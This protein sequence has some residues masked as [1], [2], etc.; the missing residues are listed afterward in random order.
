VISGPSD[1][2]DNTG[3]TSGYNN[4][5]H[6]LFFD[7]TS[8]EVSTTYSLF[9]PVYDLS[10]I[11]NPQCSFATYMQG[12]CVG[13]L[14]IDIEEPAG[15]GN[16]TNIF[17]ES[18]DIGEFWLPQIIQLCDVTETLIAFRFSVVHCDGSIGV[19]V[20]GDIA[21]DEFCV[22]KGPDCSVCSVSNPGLIPGICNDNGTPSNPNDD[23]AII[24][25]NPTGHLI[26]TNYT[27]S[28][29]VSGS[30]VYGS[31][32]NITIPVGLGDLNLS[33]TDDNDPNCINSFIVTDI[34]SC[35][36]TPPDLSPICESFEQSPLP[37]V[38]YGDVVFN[39]NGTP[40]KWNIRSTPTGTP[41]TGPSDGYNSDRYMF[42]ETGTLVSPIEAGDFGVLYTP[43]YDVS[44][45]SNPNLSFAT[46][47]YGACVGSLTVELESPIYSG[48]YT[49]IFSQS[50]NV[51]D[52]WEIQTVP[53]CDLIDTL[54]AFKITATACDGS[55]GPVNRGD[56]AIDEFC[57]Q[58]GPPCPCPDVIVQNMNSVIDGIYEADLIE[59]RAT[60]QSNGSAILKANTSIE[61]LAHFE[62]PLNAV[63]HAYIE[64]CNN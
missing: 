55:S 49:T 50:G 51:G 34:G 53:L 39:S 27:I 4:S 8:A 40:G 23:F 33:I 60:V 7:A 10:N 26:G 64:G 11:S 62:C 22:E 48:V 14:L 43:T 44:S 9:S 32:T 37:S 13:T 18:G 57:V 42:F 59:S 2:F 19:P 45:L 47:L 25:L 21:I 29:D 38:W 54:V 17:T 20:R 52:F 1:P 30:G 16:Y 3:P 24:T 61:L 28:G 5:D 41:N 58:E 36:N 31:R 46:H 35:S 12:S 56:I 6:Y 15:S 63:L